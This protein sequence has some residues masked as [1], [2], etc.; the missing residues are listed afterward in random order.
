MAAEAAA[1]ALKLRVEGM[2]CGACAL[3][4]ENGLKRLLGISE[5]NVNY[6]LGSLSLAFDQDRTSRKAIEDRIRSLGYQRHCP[7]QRAA[8]GCRRRRRPVP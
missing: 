7:P 8:R 4:I 5:I 2:D 6:G 3:K 1:T